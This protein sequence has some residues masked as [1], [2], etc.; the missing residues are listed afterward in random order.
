MVRNFRNYDCESVVFNKNV[1]VFFGENAQGKTNIIEAIYLC[2]MGKSFRA[3]KDNELINVNCDGCLV[4]AVYQ[5]ADREVKVKVALDD[6]KVVFLN[7][8]RLKRLSDLVSN[9]NV[10]VFVPDDIN[11]LKGGPENRRRFLDMMIGQLRPNYIFVLNA[12]NAALKQRNFYL[13]QIKDEGKDPSLLDVWDEKLAQFA[14]KIFSYRKDFVDKINGVIKLVHKEI[15]DDRE[16]I[17][18]EY[19]SEC[20]DKDVFKRKLLERRGLDIIKGWTTKGVHRDDFEIFLNG[21]SVK[22][23]G[24]QGQNRTAILSLKLAELSVVRDEIGESPV[25]LLDDFMSEL[26]KVRVRNFLDKI[27]DVQVFITCTEKLDIEKKDFFIYNVRDGKIY[28][29]EF[30]DGKV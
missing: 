29:E 10:V 15:T 12:Y 4:E 3:N 20:S 5:K 18:I 11:I 6:R 23:Y 14:V 9:L 30:H 17:D 21:K 25:L 26:D 28:K 2:A 24:S 7:G 8:V 22:V 19:L 13:R 1:N 27:G 16:L